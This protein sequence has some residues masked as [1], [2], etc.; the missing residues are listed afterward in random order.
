MSASS[1]IC[2]PSLHAKS[3]F[4]RVMTRM[5]FDDLSKLSKQQ[6][7]RRIKKWMTISSE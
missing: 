5:P 1:L 4:L 2:G 7:T 6:N 3:S